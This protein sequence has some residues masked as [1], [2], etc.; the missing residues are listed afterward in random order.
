[1]PDVIETIA[2]LAQYKQT[3]DAVQQPATER[4]LLCFVA[5]VLGVSPDRVME[6]LDEHAAEIEII[7]APD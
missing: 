3:A 1:M 2:I 4:V 7:N 5:N 6:L